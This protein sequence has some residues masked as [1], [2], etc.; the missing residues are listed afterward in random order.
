M[1]HSATLL[2]MSLAGLLQK[3][4]SDEMSLNKSWHDVEWVAFD[5]ETTGKYPVESEICELAAVKWKNGEIVG[6]FQ[7]LFSVSEPMGQVVINIHKITNEMLEG[8]PKIDEKLQEFVDFVGEGF[9]LAHHAP[10]DMGFLAVDFER[11]KIKFP[12]NPVFCTSLLARKLIPASPNH[13]LQTLIPFL[14]LPKRT[15]HRALSDAESCMDLGLK[16]FE[17]FGDGSLE[18]MMALQGR[19]LNWNDF[20][21]QS[22]K[23]DERW[24][25]M[26]EALEKK[27]SVE[28]S[29]S[30]G[31]RPGQAR[32]VLP[33]GLVMSPGQDFLVAREEVG[34]HPKRY[35]LNRISSSQ[36]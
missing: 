25:A 31:S 26:V 6:S 27:E 24:K 29:Y 16:C 21:I 1:T 2:R 17:A 30:G 15:A 10:F 22:L 18:E 36:P 9:L 28:I 7:S 4:N 23:S 8:A 35:Y 19:N 3:C 5:T 33:V 14:G 32:R 34:A 12:H 13:R 11:L 20:S